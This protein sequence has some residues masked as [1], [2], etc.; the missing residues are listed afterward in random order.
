[1]RILKINR[2][3]LKEAVKVLEKGGVIVYPT[4]TAY[5]L[6]ADACN[7]K[8]VDKIYQ[9]KGRDF[10]KPLPVIVSSLKMVEE[11][12]FLDER[13]LK[14]ATRFWPGPLTMVLK[15][16]KKPFLWDGI[17]IQNTLAL[18]LPASD[19][20]LAL[21]EE[22]GRPIIAT[23]ANLSGQKEC[24][25]IKSLL[26]QFKSSPFS[27]LIDLI[28][29]AGKLPKIPVS[30]IIDLSKKEPLILREGPIKKI[31]LIKALRS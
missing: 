28:L 8:A 3:S 21:V 4:D 12:C 19:I 7:K 2:S 10:N 17:K 18:R 24:Y 22:L 6:G 29:D 20:A 23:S 26:K 13:V 5:S 15:K 25:E 27:Q 31:T 1:M 16:K 14:L 11:Y 30:T 9:I